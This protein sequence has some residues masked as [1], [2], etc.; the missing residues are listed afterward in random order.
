MMN[1]NV[2]NRLMSPHIGDKEKIRII[3]LL[4]SLGISHYF[5]KE[6]EEIVDQ[7]FGKLNDIIA[8]EDDLETISLMFEVFRLYGHKMSCGKNIIF[9]GSSH[10]YTKHSDDYMGFI[11]YRCLRKIQRRRWE[12]Q[13]ESSRRC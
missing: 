8:K 11:N 1:P 9:L 3:H 13:G 10:I 5:D 6:I 2:R 4:I 12:V 7:A